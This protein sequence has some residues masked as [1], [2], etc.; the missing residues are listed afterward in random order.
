MD[1]TCCFTEEENLSVGLRECAAH[2]FRS[3]YLTMS[4]GL[5]DHFFD[6]DNQDATCSCLF[7]TVDD[8]PEVIFLDNRM[9]G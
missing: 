8:V 9:Q 6:R 5:A 2:D 7:E 4:T 3:G 1:R